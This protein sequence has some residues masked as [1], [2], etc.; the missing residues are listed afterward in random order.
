MINFQ[1]SSSILEPFEIIFDLLSQVIV[2]GHKNVQ[3]NKDVHL[4]VTILSIY[5][6]LHMVRDAK[7]TLPCVYSYLHRQQSD[8]LILS[9]MP[10]YGSDECRVETSCCA[11]NQKW[12][13]V[14]IR[15]YFIKNFDIF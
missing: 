5:R 6:V 13:L 3:F 12:D 14:E 2:D 15:S 11:L 4:C 9:N 8:N 10:A 1:Y 7:C